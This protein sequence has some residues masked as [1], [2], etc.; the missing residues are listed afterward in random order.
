MWSNRR[1]ETY[2]KQEKNNDTELNGKER[3]RRFQPAALADRRSSVQWIQLISNS[4]GTN[5][6]TNQQSQQ[7]QRDQ[8]SD[9]VWT[10]SQ[11]SSSQGYSPNPSP[12]RHVFARA[13][14]NASFYRP[15]RRPS[16]RHEGHPLRI[17]LRWYTTTNPKIIYIPLA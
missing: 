17:V 4:T 3:E 16:W 13:S 8:L 6:E 14:K 12:T 7:Q 9:S 1:H 11:N 5:S 15:L 10:S 2:I